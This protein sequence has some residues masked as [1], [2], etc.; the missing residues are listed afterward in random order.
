MRPSDAA[1]FLKNRETKL[2]QIIF[3]IFKTEKAFL[4]NLIVSQNSFVQSLF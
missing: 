3:E 4:K 2:K 1:D